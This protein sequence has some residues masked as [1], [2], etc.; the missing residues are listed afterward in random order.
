MPGTRP[1]SDSRGPHDQQHPAP[2]AQPAAAQRHAAPALRAVHPGRPDRPH[3]AH[4]AHDPG[5][6]LVRGRPARRQPGADR[7]DEPGAQAGDVRAARADGLQGD[8]GRLPGGE[9]DRLRLRP[10]AHRGGPDPRRR[11]HPGADPGPRG[12]DRAH[13]RVARA[14][15][16][17]R[18]CTSTTRPRRCSAAS[19]SA[20]TRTASSTSPSGAR[21]LCKKFEELDPGHR[22]LLRVLPGVLHRH[23]AR[24]R[25][26]G[27][28]RGHRR[29]RADRRATR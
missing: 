7:P 12:A 10:D 24:V 20:S 27:L 11:R 16:S 4:P 14:A 21:E 28:Q 13:L 15:P 19:S 3:L 22:R 9:P 6:A 1:T 25:R 2:R 29:V 26:P 17:R 5:A 18:S 23:R 8:R